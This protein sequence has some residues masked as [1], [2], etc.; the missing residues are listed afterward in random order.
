MS[1]TDFGAFPAVTGG[2]YAAPATS[3][4]ATAPERP[5]W[6]NVKAPDARSQQSTAV[7]I[8]NGRRALKVFLANPNA[9]FGTAFLALV[10][11]VA[12]LAPVLYPDDPL[13]MV[14]KPF[15][16]PGQDPAFPLGTDALG[17]DV[18]AGILHGSRIS[19]FVGL[20]ATA[21]GLTFGV[22]VGA[23]AGYFGGW[24]DDLLVRLIEIFQTLP[25]FVLLVVL[26]A[27]VQ[28]S[29]STVTLAIAVI[30]WPTVARLTRAEFRAIREKDF[31]MAARSLGFG[32]GRIIFREILPNALP[33]IIVTSSVMVAT[34]ILMES[35]LSFMGL[36]DPNVVSWGSM[37][38]TGREL[39]RTAWYLTALPGLAIVFTVLAL[40]LI[41]DGLNDALNPRFTGDR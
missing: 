2:A 35:A 6:S 20:M 34:A 11:A 19:L 28:P 29:A 8:T 32:H 12:L 16:W 24:I 37:I 38:G 23:I 15:L 1:A 4:Q 31:V 9:L 39:V 14:G 40:N 22:I 26:V 17:R 25:S 33:P 36:G 3:E 21:L 7:A 27:I 13:S 41:G 30:S 5:S 18:L 10:I